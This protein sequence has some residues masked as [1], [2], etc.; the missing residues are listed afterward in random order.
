MGVG[1]SMALFEFFQSR[2]ILNGSDTINAFIGSYQMVY[3]YIIF[4]II[5]G[6]IFSWCRGNKKSN[7][8]GCGR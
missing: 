3:N 7:K 4:I 6:L 1:L 2:Y 5:P 8:S